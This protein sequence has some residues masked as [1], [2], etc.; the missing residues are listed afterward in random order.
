MKRGCVTFIAYKCI[1]IFNFS[2]KAAMKIH[3]EGCLDIFSGK[4]KSN[5]GAVGGIG[6]GIGL[7]Q[8]INF[9]IILCKSLW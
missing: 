4:I 9:H 8:V 3:T 6:I 5:I 2:L 7:L 1:I